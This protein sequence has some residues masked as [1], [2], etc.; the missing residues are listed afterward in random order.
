[1]NHV[2]APPSSAPPTLATEVAKLWRHRLWVAIGTLLTVAGAAIWAFTTPNEYLATGAFLPPNFDDVKSL[3]FYKGAYKGMGAADVEDL[4]RVAA[5][6]QSDTA[7]KL[8]VRHF[9][10]VEHYRLGGISDPNTLEKKL[11]TKYKD[12]VS[13]GLS[14]NSVVQIKVH[15]EDSKRAARMVNYFI[16]YAD[17]FVESV[18]RRKEALAA[19][20][21]S[22]ERWQVERQ[23][24]VDT[25][26]Q[27]RVRH[28][29]YHFDYLSEEVSRLL[30]PYI[31]RAEFHAQYDKLRSAEHLQEHY[32]NQIAELTAEII[33]REENLR[34]YPSLV[35]V[36][37][38]GV[39]AYAKDRPKRSI[40]LLLGFIF[41][42]VG[43]SLV[44]IVWKDRL[45]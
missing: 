26:A 22:L 27:L 41:G 29:L 16:A 19:A 39:P 4:E 31:Q 32:E 1:M 38:W 34:A 13:I 6:L 42:F 3:N 11:R 23:R 10:L 17:S 35:T 5:A 45:E 44:V 24:L 33:F 28:R 18:A 12:N 30:L 36:M 15:D 37:A 21:N 2:P 20:R 40:Y 14:A 9:N 7:F 25:L 43:S 8:V